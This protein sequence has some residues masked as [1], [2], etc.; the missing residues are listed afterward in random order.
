MK[1]HHSSSLITC[2]H[3]VGKGQN[4]ADSRRDIGS[5]VSIVV[6][7]MELPNQLQLETSVPNDLVP[8]LEVAR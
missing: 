2:V 5:I 7:V 4:T 3:H 6:N 1:T 8:Y